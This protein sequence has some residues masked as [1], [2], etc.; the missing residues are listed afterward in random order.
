MLFLYIWT[1]FSEKWN[2]IVSFDFEKYERGFCFKIVSF[3]N[4]GYD[5]DN[6]DDVDDDDDDD[7]DAYYTAALG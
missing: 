3:L 6:D 7:D 2:K 5:D 4:K 1:T